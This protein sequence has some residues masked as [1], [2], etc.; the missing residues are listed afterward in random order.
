MCVLWLTLIML[1]AAILVASFDYVFGWVLAYYVVIVRVLNVACYC[2]LFVFVRLL[3]TVLCV[4]LLCDINLL[5]SV[6]VFG[7][8]NSVVC[9]CCMF[10]FF[11][12]TNVKVFWLFDFIVGLVC[13]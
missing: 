10:V 7:V 6:Y 4:R 12:L 13:C 8:V 3:L 9:V 1:I 11:V 2:C 5:F